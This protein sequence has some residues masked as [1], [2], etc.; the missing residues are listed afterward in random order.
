MLVVGLAPTLGPIAGAAL[1]GVG[2]WQLGFGVLAA[3]SVLAF[4][5]VW[6]GLPETLPPGVRRPLTPRALAG[7]VRALVSDRAFVAPA[8]TLCFSFAMMFTYISAFS[9]VSQRQFGLSPQGFSLAFAANTVALIAG[10]QIN[11]AL[12]GRVAAERRLLG[13][14]VA[15]LTSVGAL[16]VLGLAHRASLPVVLAALFAMM[17]SVGFVMPNASTLAIISQRPNVAGTASA[18]LGTLQMGVGGA[19]A[20]TAGFTPSGHATLASMVTVMGALGAVALTTCAV[21]TL[22][23]SRPA[24][25]RPGAQSQRVNARLTSGSRSAE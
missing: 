8:L 23:P 1:L 16:G 5:L 24:T 13:G 19:L 25:P 9:S 4:A 15:A 2:P 3:I 12:I 14:L 6:F 22:R 11:A 20:A 7:T 18:L 17:F 21:L 10:A